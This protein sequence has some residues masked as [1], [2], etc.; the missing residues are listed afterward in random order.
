MARENRKEKFTQVT[1]VRKNSTGK[2]FHGEKDTVSPLLIVET[3]CYE[4]YK[5]GNHGKGVFV[6]RY[7]KTYSVS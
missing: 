5:I 1:M 7:M 4:R 2:N 3:F 6:V